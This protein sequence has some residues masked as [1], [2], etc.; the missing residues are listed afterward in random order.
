M[1]DI[2]SQLGQFLSN[3]TDTAIEGIAAATGIDKSTVSIGA[4]AALTTLGAVAAGTV[5]AFK[6]SGAYRKKPIESTNNNPASISQ[7]D[8]QPVINEPKDELQKQE[9]QTPQLGSGEIISELEAT[10]SDEQN[11]TQVH[12]TVESSGDSDIPNPSIGERV[13]Q[14]ELTR[15]AKFGKKTY[16]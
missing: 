15:S 14:G 5:L 8:T 4:A 1:T 12:T 3:N 10:P 2:V 11:A 6:Y 13:G 9:E 7:N 16:K